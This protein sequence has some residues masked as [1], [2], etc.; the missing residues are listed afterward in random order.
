MTHFEVR[1]ATTEADRAAV[2]RLR[3]ELYVEEQG[4]FGDTADHERRWLRDAM[5][6]EATLLV[7]YEGTEVVGTVRL[8]H[9]GDGRIDAE[10][11]HTFDLDAFADVLDER[12]IIVTSRMLVRA[13]HRGGELPRMIL[14]R[15]FELAVGSGAELLVGECEPHLVNTWIRLGFHPYGLCEHPVNGTLIRIALV[16]GD[17][18]HV[19]K[20]G[21]PLAPAAERYAKGVERPLALRELLRRSQQVISEAEGHTRF[22]EAIDRAVARAELSRKLGDLSDEELDALLGEGHVLDCGAGSVLIRRGHV[23]RTLYVL[24]GG[25]LLVSD[26][27]RVIVEVAEP[28]DILGEVAFFTDGERMSDVLAGASGARVLAL[29]E[30][31]LKALVRDHGA[32]AAKLLLSMTRGLCLKLRQRATKP[33]EAVTQLGLEAAAPAG[34]GG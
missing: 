20:L 3:Y 18:E 5:D 14:V 9:G 25:S 34:D 6:D 7:A 30:R 24:L 13:Q 22:F 21:S 8:L 26:H 4:L 1:T 23:S 11:R 33:S 28:G 2:Y 19:R 17:K 10:T 12:H 16:V 32:G 15:G 27:G 31:S 29:S